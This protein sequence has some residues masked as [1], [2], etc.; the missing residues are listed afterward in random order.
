VEE[1]GERG[2]SGSPL[3]GGGTPHH[4]VG[5]PWLAEQ[6]VLAGASGAVPGSQREAHGLDLLPQRV[7]RA[8]D[9][10]Q[11]LAARRRR[12]PGGVRLLRLRLP[13]HLAGVDGALGLGAALDGQWLDDVAG[14][15][16]GFREGGLVLSSSSRR[17]DTGRT[18][19]TRCGGS[20]L[21]CPSSMC[22]LFVY[23]IVSVRGREVGF[24]LVYTP[25]H[26]VYEGQ[27][28]QT[29]TIT[30]HTNVCVVIV[31]VCH[32]HSTLKTNDKAA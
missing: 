9:L 18:A 28:H 7:E 2:W 1:R 5:E 21:L 3:P 12:R 25:T 19:R 29:H 15:A 31:C 14:G 26:R 32:P 4:T 8:E 17:S 20:P 10:L 16:L 11:A 24:Q 22:L 6:Q 13:H 30:T 23:A 27:T